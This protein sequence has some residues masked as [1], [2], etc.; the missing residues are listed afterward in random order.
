MPKKY[1]IIKKTQDISPQIQ[2]HP[3]KGESSKKSLL[4]ALQNM[5]HLFSLVVNTSDFHPRGPV[6]DPR[7][8]PRNFSLL[9]LGERVIS[10]GSFFFPNAELHF[11]QQ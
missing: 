1:V 6:F 3:L 5:D 11:G 9:I 10:N 8:Y 2:I 7:L 4:S